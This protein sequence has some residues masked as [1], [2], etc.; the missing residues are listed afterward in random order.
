MQ[1]SNITNGA[2][3]LNAQISLKISKLATQFLL[4]YIQAYPIVINQGKSSLKPLCLELRGQPFTPSSALAKEQNQQIN[5][6]PLPSLKLLPAE[7]N[8]NTTCKIIQKTLVPTAAV[9]S[10]INAATQAHTYVCPT[11]HCSLKSKLIKP[12]LPF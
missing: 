9:R 5:A 3:L 1:I 7:R 12:C 4:A 2:L 11:D 10:V 8:V 6:P